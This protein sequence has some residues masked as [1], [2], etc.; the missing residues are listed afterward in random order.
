MQI[1]LLFSILAALTLYI[2]RG[3]PVID[4][5]HFVPFAPHGTA[6]IF[7]TAGFVFVSFGGLLKVASLAEEIKDPGRVLPLGMIIALFVE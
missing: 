1:I 6:A 7:A 5:Q 2:I 4:F 3:I